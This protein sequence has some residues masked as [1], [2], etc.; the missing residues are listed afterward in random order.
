MN[1][2]YQLIIAVL[3]GSL[4]AFTASAQ[5]A[6]VTKELKLTSTEVLASSQAT[7]WRLPEQRKPNV[8]ASLANTDAPVVFELAEDFAPKHIA[9]LRT[10][11]KQKYF[12]GLAVIRSQDNYVAQWGDP[13]EDEGEFRSLGDAAET[14]E[15]EFYRAKKG[16]AL[17]NIVSRDAYADEVGFVKGFAVGADA[18]GSKQCSGARLANPLLWRPWRRAWHGHEQ[19]QCFWLVRGYRAFSTPP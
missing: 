5:N 9:N 19:R 15:P 11:V 6:L 18:K 7:D 12:D 14:V 2:I 4:L 16:L 1:K 3:T 10:L 17:Q 13:A 8:R